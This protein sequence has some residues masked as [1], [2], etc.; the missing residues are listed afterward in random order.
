MKVTKNYTIDYELALK[1]EQEKNASGLINSLL[2]EHYG[3]DE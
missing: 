3:K 2:V 1:L